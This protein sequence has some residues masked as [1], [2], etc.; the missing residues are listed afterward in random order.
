MSW[1]AFG[2]APEKAHKVAEYM[3][4]WLRVQAVDDNV[5]IRGIVGSSFGQGKE[6]FVRE[7]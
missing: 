1:S 5:S 6:W 4:A 7:R 3:V 2:T